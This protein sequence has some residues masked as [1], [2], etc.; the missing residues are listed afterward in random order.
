[1]LAAAAASWVPTAHL[2]GGSLLEAQA[3]DGAINRIWSYPASSAE[4]LHSAAQPVTNV[5][6]E[7]KLLPPI[8][9]TSSAEQPVAALLDCMRRRPTV[10]GTLESTCAP[11][12][13]FE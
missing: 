13:A 6:H 7:L 9:A 4:T 5:P 1:M 2:T 12:A 3:T 8:M 11:I 10:G